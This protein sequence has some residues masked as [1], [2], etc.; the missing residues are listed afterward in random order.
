MSRSKSSKV[1][2]AILRANAHCNGENYLVP[3]WEKKVR[4][5][6][7][8]IARMQKGI[9]RG[10]KGL[11]GALDSD[12][13]KLAR[14]KQNKPSE[15]KL[16]PSKVKSGYLDGV[17]F[18]KTREWREIRYKALRNNDGRCELCGRGKK[19][20]IILHVDHIKPRS[21]FPELELDLN[22]LQILCEDCNLGKSNKC[23]RDWRMK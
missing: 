8:T 13:E 11:E 23:T 4:K 17:D 18:Y 15:R 2:R 9:M 14:L 5:L 22:N 21:R 10:V 16:G 20:G 3:R 1:K 12:V 19:D 7:N 6:E